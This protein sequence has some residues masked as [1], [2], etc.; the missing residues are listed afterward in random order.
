MKIGMT[1]NRNGIS[2]QS[3]N[4]LKEL[5]KSIE[6]TEAHHGD[7]TGADENFHQIMVSFLIKI[8]IHPPD[9]NIC[10]AYCQGDEIRKEKSYLDIVLIKTPDLK[11]FDFKYR[12]KDI[13]NECDALL[14][15]PSSKTET[16]R[17][18]TWST[19]RYAKKT[20]KKTI[21]FYPDGT[22]S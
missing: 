6:I 1:G 7:C 21:I 22:T 2:E 17:S 15:F 3:S 9:K 10:R 4:K 16:L 20:N 19:I 12:N 11:S 8:I 5:L 14:A 18:G 13:V